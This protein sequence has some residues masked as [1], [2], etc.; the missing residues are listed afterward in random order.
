MK[1]PIAFDEMRNTELLSLARRCVREHNDGC[2][3]QFKL[4]KK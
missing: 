3:E 4:V 1:A 2:L